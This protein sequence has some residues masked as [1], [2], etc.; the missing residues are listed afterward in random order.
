VNLSLDD[1][2]EI[3]KA[4]H[5]SNA[6]KAMALLWYHD[7]LQPGTTMTSGLL[8]TL[9]SDHHVG[10]PNST[11]LAQTIRKT[12]LANETKKGFSLKPGSRKIICDWLPS[13]IDGMEPAM[14]HSLGYLPEAVWIGT[15]RYIETV[16]RQINGCVR[17]TYYDAAAVMLRRLL[18]TLIIEAYE[19]LKR[20][21]EIKDGGGTGNYFMLKDLVER[22]CGERGHAGLNLG[23]D[24]KAT[25][26]DGRDVGNWSAHARRY[27]A[28]AA[29]LT[30]IQAGVR[31]A[32]QELAQIANLKTTTT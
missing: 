7:Q 14:N 2:C 5:K 18:E 22:A 1:F 17:A 25:L 30:R 19:Y 16:C 21:A 23:R 13:G 3:V 4:L 29:D 8:T 9:L 20:E 12:K 15:R 32:V 6:E 27:N 28:V 26:K 24:S 31:V 11:Q 10:T